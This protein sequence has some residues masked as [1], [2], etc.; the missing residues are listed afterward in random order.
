M[1]E[2]APSPNGASAWLV[3]TLSLTGTSGD[4]WEMLQ[5]LAATGFVE[6]G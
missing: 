2:L 1:R 3:D 6:S 4:Y 5:A